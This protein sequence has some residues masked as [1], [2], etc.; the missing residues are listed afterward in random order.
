MFNARQQE[1][2]NL[3]KEHSSIPT[4]EI[5]KALKL[6]RARIHQLIVPLI[7]KGLVKK[8]RLSAYSRPR[9]GGIIGIK[10]R[11]GDE[12]IQVKLTPGTLK[13]I[14]ASKK[15]NA[16][17]FHESDVRE[18]GR[19][20]M[21][22]RGIKLA[23]KDEVIGMEVALET[24]QLLTVTENGYGKRTPIPEYR[25]ISRGGK[26]VINIKTSER[27]GNV[28]GIKTVKEEDEVMVISKNGIVIRIPVSGVAN[29]G[30]NTQ[31]VRIMKLREGDKVTTVERVRIEH[32]KDD[33]E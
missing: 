22:V 7:K 21:G 30:R 28:V 25:L 14:L 27:N 9:V 6:T 8:T 4:K 18:S 11:E 32:A 5:Q 10:L 1:I 3:L 33:N 31:G 24:G 12:L 17:R 26:G 13:F 2:L 15:G 29:I 19:N 23:K 16:V 20:S